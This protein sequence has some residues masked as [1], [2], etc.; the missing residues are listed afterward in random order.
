MKWKVDAIENNGRPPI[1]NGKP[2]QKSNPKNSQVVSIFG[3]P[4]PQTQ[5]SNLRKEIH[6]NK[7]WNIKYIPF[8]RPAV[9]AFNLAIFKA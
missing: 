1:E 5:K 8:D 4:K 7:H 2:P 9:T 6:D 3:S